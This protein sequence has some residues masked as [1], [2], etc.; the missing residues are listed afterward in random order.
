MLYFNLVDW[1]DENLAWKIT[2]TPFF[3]TE[4]IAVCIALFAN[5]VLILTTTCK[6]DVKAAAHL[7]INSVFHCSKLYKVNRKA[8]KSE[9]RPFSTWYINSTWQPVLFIDNNQIWVNA[10][11][12]S[13]E[14]FWTVVLRSM[15]TC[16]N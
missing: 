5:D 10:L 4:T 13:L 3:G 14:S 7:I 2:K 9:V 1:L 6:K 8:D 15:H 12:I 16:R 11:H